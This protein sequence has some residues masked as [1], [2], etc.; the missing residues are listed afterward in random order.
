MSDNILKNILAQYNRKK[1]KAEYD[2][3]IRKQEL[4]KKFPQLQEIDD[5]LTSLAISTAKSLINNNDK[6]VLNKLNSDID[7]L[8]NKKIQILKSLNISENYFLPKYECSICKDT[9]Y[10]TNQDYVSSMWSCLKQKLFDLQYNKANISNFNIQNFDTFS[11]MFYSDEVNEEKYH[12]NISPRENINIIKKICFN[13]IENFDNKEQHNLLFTGNTGLGKTFLSSSI[14]NELIKKGKNV[15]YQTAPVMLDSI[16]DY[17]FGQSNSSNVLDS[18]LNVDLLIID[19]LGTECINNM[20]FS[21]LF[22]IIN[23]RLLNQNKI[24][25]TIISTNLSLKNLY[26][27]YDERI[28][29]RIVGNYDICYFFGEDIRFKIRK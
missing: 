14:A 2:A 11:D 18:I 8:K 24:T 20:K 5:K 4:Y 29:S 6:E 26:S 9:G 17:R 21:E 23:T 22:N 15:L 13:F 12:S 28:V 7:A 3:E 1:V 27:N 10:V 16:I 19:D 25:K